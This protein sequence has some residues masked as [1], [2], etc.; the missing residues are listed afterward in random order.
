MSGMKHQPRFANLGFAAEDRQP[1]HEHAWYCVLDR[2][3]F[4]QIQFCRS[5]GIFVAFYLRPARD[6]LQLLRGPAVL[7]PVSHI[8][9]RRTFWPMLREL[10]RADTL[11]NAA[12]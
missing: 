4:H 12:E 11:G 9:F 10:N 3:K 1:F 7:Q 5:K 2:L 8:A 6:L